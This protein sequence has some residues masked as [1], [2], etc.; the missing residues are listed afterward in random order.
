MT[1]ISRALPNS[2]IGRQSTIQVAKTKHD[3][4][5]PANDALT[6]PTA[7]RLDS[8]FTN[9]NGAMTT[10]GTTQATQSTSAAAA[11]TAFD[12]AKM[13][14]SHFIQVFFL[15]IDRGVYAKEQKAFYGMDVSQTALPRLVTIAEVLQWGER[16]KTGDPLRVTAGGAAMSNPTIAQCNTAYD[17][18]VTKNNILNTDKEAHDTALE[19]VE[20]M[21]TEADHVI[22]KVW[23][24]VETF[25]NEET[26]SSKRANARLWGVVYVSKGPAATIKVT[27]KDFATDLPIAGAA[28]KIESVGDETIT[29]AEGVATITTQVVGDELIVADA[30]GYARNAEPLTVEEGGNYDMVIKLTHV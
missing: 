18:W 22:L 24:E 3:I 9:Y 12:K 13:F 28:V 30:T 15:G 1:T 4:V 29:D 2:N 20:A 10:V 16:L 17:D 8:I 6:T 11:S 21:N 5:L 7:T 19:A 14:I 23:D 25:Y 27:V 26:P